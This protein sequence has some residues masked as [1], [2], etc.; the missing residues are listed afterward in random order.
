MPL[1]NGFSNVGIEMR[2]DLVSARKMNLRKMIHETIQKYPSLKKRFENAKIVDEVRG[3][4][5]PIGSR[6][7]KISG[8]HFMLIGD[9]ASLVDPFTGEGI[10]NAMISGMLAAKQAMKCIQKSNY[11][12]SLLSKYDEEVYKRLMPGLKLSKRLQWLAKFPWLFNIVI[13]K[14]AK[15]KLLAETISYIFVDPIMRKRLRNPFFYFKVLFFK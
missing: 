2:S 14:A 12:Q 9:A 10:G 8:H 11:S 5:L 7:R 3:Y 1:S 4:S 13:S 6:N 15:S